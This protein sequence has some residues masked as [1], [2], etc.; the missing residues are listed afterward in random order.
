MVP[1][2]REFVQPSCNRRKH[3]RL[4]ED[5]DKQGWKGRI[6]SDEASQTTSE[7]EGLI[8]TVMGSHE[9][10]NHKNGQIFTFNRIPWLQY[11]KWIGET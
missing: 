4:R 3:G 1:R 11:G 2:Q 9:D 8:L 5:I 10:F 7:M 6:L